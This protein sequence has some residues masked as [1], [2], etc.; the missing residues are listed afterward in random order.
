MSSQNKKEKLLQIVHNF[1]L[2]SANVITQ[3]RSLVPNE[4]NLNQKTNKWFNIET[5][6]TVKDDLKLWKS[7][8]QNLPPMVIETYLDL[9]DFNSKQSL[10]LID[11]DHNTWD[12]NTKKSEIVI[13]RWLI[14]L[15]PNIMDNYD[16]DL[17]ILY[18]KLIITFRYLYTMSRLLPSFRLLK[19]LAAN[20]FTNLPL[21]VGTR[22]LDGNRS[23]LSKGRIGLSKQIISNSRDHLTQKTI[24]PVAT[25]LGSLKISVSYRNDVGFQVNETEQT[26]SNIFNTIDYSASKPLV[27]NM[28]KVF[29]S[30]TVSP[31]STS[32]NLTRN[33]SNASIAQNLKIQRIGS[34]GMTSQTQP[35][36]QPNAHPL[37]SSPIPRS[38]PSSI[39]SNHGFPAELSSSGGT[40]RYS[41]SFGRTTRR[42]SLRRSSSMEKPIPAPS[43]SIDDNL[44]DF[45]KM[46]DSKQ[47]LRL[48]YNSNIQDSLGRFQM[49]RSRN[50]LLTESMSASLYSKSTSPPS[51]NPPQSLQLG[52]SLIP[53]QQSHSYQQ[54]LLRSGSRSP[55]HSPTTKPNLSIS[56]RHYLPLITSRMSE[57]NIS[58]ESLLLDHERRYSSPVEEDL[59]E[60]KEDRGSDISGNGTSPKKITSVPI[61]RIA[62]TSPNSLNN[63]I[64]RMSFSVGPSNPTIAAT[65]THAK[66]HKPQ[67]SDSNAPNSGHSTTGED[68]Y[69]DQ[70]RRL[71]TQ[72]RGGSHIHG[73]G[74]GHT[75]G[76]ADEDDDLLFTMSDMN[77][78]K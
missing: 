31:P 5:F 20:N 2:K 67:S 34:I 16:E 45:V 21:R 22:I 12:V 54:R 51:G 42:S 29:K 39:N 72:L 38:I 78:T 71:S 30:G 49:M 75:H 52:T 77:L 17:P 27:T 25:S 50:D 19:K 65:Q 59:E 69:S 73:H 10:S 4:P 57:G 53:I 35:S 63:I 14:E 55:S 26:L 6:D 43:S 76:H 7:S 44:K 56:P 48:N 64:S 47:D 9:R 13:E 66:L 58:N 41:S 68:N 62:S 3:S 61:S 11:E 36:A 15:D 18:K 32:P 40:P 8:G 33:E 24:T 37:P 60:K 28:R 46:M 1:F 74:H 23:I 70:G